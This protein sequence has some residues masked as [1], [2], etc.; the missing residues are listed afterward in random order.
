M[1]E[2]DHFFV[3]I[4]FFHLLQ[5]IANSY[6]G[7][8][9]R[10]EDVLQKAKTFSSSEWTDSCSCCIVCVENHSRWSGGF[11]L[12]CVQAKHYIPRPR[13]TVVKNVFWSSDSCWPILGPGDA[14]HQFILAALYKFLLE[15]SLSRGIW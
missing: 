4:L 12:L 15:A 7:T 9:N 3:N 1:N 6:P 10:C 2:S 14:V 8:T 5:N 11:W 13:I